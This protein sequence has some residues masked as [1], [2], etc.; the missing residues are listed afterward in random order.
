MFRMNLKYRRWS[1][2][3]NGYQIRTHATIA[4]LT[5]KLE[6]RIGGNVSVVGAISLMI[7]RMNA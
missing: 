5:D 4:G 2:W 6:I 7:R 3:Q 1:K